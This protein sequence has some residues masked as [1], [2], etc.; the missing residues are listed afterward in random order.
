MF[1]MRLIGGMRYR[2]GAGGDVR[3]AWRR[4]FSR[5][6]NF[7]RLP[8]F[9]WIFVRHKTRALSRLELGTRWSHRRMPR[10]IRL[11]M[12]SDVDGFALRLSAVGI[13]CGGVPLQHVF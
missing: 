10:R 13:G 1:P 2:N 8:L 3:V 9:G 12:Q 5:Q 6:M 11:G 4:R 7:D